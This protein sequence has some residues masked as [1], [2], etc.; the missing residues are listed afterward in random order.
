M[1]KTV[2]DELDILSTEHH[3][4]YFN[5]KKGNCSDVTFYSS[6]KSELELIS[7][8]INDSD[9]KLRALYYIYNKK[10]R[11]SYNKEICSY[12]YYWIDNVSYA[13]FNDTL[14]T[15]E[16]DIHY[17]AL[18]YKLHRFC[19]VEKKQNMHCSVFRT[20][21]PEKDHRIL[22]ALSYIQEGTSRRIQLLS[23]KDDRQLFPQAQPSGHDYVTQLDQS[24]GTFPE[25]KSASQNDESV[26]RYSQIITD[27]TFSA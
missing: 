21:F 23:N 11:K 10:Q 3:Y 16:I 22:P 24:D 7:N 27:I 2:N 12:L 1:A 8:V 9:K 25:G 17:V 19:G 18:R 4:Y 26:T 5:F 6:I 15:K 14:F 13:S 20:L